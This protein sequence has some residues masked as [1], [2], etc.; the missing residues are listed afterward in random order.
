MNRCRCTC[1]TGNESENIKIFSKNIPCLEGG[2]SQNAQTETRTRRA[3]AHTQTQTDKLRQT[4][5]RTDGHGMRRTDREVVFKI[6][7]F[8]LLNATK[9][10]WRG[11]DGV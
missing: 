11:E 10:S 5:R 6:E 4:D 9:K 8:R 3:S 2:V 1:F 7:T